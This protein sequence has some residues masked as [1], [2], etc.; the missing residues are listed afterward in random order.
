MAIGEL[1]FTLRSLDAQVVNHLTLRDVK[2]ETKL[3]IEVHIEK[4]EVRRKM[5]EVTFLNFF[6]LT[7]YFLL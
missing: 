5:S 6:L 7:S 3:V 4:Q 1:T 2:A